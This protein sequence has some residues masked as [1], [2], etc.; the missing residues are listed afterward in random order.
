MTITASTVLE[1]EG[2]TLSNAED[3]LTFD[4]AGR[5]LV[6]FSLMVTNTNTVREIIRI[7]LPELVFEFLASWCWLLQRHQPNILNGNFRFRH[8][9]RFSGRRPE[10]GRIG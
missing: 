10:P 3:S 8:C 9:E 4:E 6:T 7:V 1:N 5:Y 2:F